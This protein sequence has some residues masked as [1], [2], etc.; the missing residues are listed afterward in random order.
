MGSEWDTGTANAIYQNLEYMESYNPDYVLVLS[1]DHIYKMDYQL[2]LDFHKAQK[3]GITIAVRPA[4]VEEAGGFGIVVTDENKKIT[5]F[6]GPTQ[7]A[8]NNL[9]GM[10]IYIFSWKI[11]KEVLEKLAGQ[12]E[13]E[14]R[15]HVIPRCQEMNVP[16]YAYEFHSY[17]NDV[18]TL[19][20]YWQAN[21]ELI[22]VVPE[23]N[24]YEEYWKIYTKNEVRS[25]Q[26]LAKGSVVE[27]SIIGEGSD[28]YG[29]IYNSVI[30]CG[31]TVGKDTVVRNSIIMNHV[32][33]GDGCEIDKAVIAENA[34]VGKSV[35]MG[36]LL[37]ERENET[38]PQIY[39]HGIV[40][41]GEKSVIPDGVTIGKNSVI[42][43]KTEISDYENST[44]LSGRTLI[45]AGE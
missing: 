19:N 26:Y 8:E 24:F 7:A 6:E 44:L 14:L 22:D 13:L 29:R 31:V 5:D 30:G 41:V 1:G 34:I 15:R 11:L 45:R 43:G 16:M 38:A 37:I 3:A 2:M 21:M 33:L 35:K 17:W 27:K 28:I 40:T 9:A 20:S 4:S 36:T 10:G 23:F 12:S 25:P 18:G 32:K 42:S 39:N